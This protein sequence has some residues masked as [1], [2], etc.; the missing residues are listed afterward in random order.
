[1]TLNTIFR[2]TF[3]F[4]YFNKVYTHFLVVKI[5]FQLSFGNIMIDF[6][7]I[8][9]NILQI[10]FFVI[11]HLFKLI[12]QTNYRSNKYKYILFDSFYKSY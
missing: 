9:L 8:F 10:F 6:N 3:I 1:M 2:S 7:M 5:K 4:F 11:N 12:V